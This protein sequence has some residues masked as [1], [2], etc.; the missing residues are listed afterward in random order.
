M[1]NARGKIRYSKDREFL[2][3]V[4]IELPP[5]IEASLVAKAQAQ[6]LPL[7]EYVT[8]LLRK[9]S[10]VLSPEERAAGWRESAKNLP[11]TPT[12]SDDA[13]SRDGIYSD[14]D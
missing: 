7:P 9:H 1:R 11:P 10:V 8:D 2:M 13:M 3:T 14:H 5:E 12:L 6:G 4:T